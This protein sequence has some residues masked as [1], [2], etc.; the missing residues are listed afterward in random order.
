MA[1]PVTFGKHGTRSA[2]VRL[3]LIAMA[4]L[5]SLSSPV[6]A[7]PS[8]LTSLSIEE[9][10]DLKVTSVSKK[11]QHLSD[12][13]AAIYVITN[14]DLRR[15]GVTHIPDALRMVPG[16]NVARIT[17]NK[18]AVNSRG[19]TSR[20]SDKLL[21]LIDGRSIY[22]PDFSGVLW[23]IQDV[24]IDDIERIEVIRGP[25][26]TLWGANAVNGVIN[27]I[28]KSAA[29][30]QG[31]LVS[32]GA[33][34]Y[35][36]A[37]A[38]LRYGGRIGQSTHYR[39]FAKGFERDSFKYSDDGDA[40]DDW[41]MR[42]AGF[43]FDSELTAGDSLTVQGDFFQSDSHRLM[44]LPSTVPP[45]VMSVDDDSDASGQ[46]MLTRWQRVFS[47]TSDLT[48]QAYYNRNQGEDAWTDT[49]RDT[50]DVDLQH[51]FR[52][53]E[54]HDIIWGIR[55]NRTQDEFDNT[56]VLFLDPSKRTDNLYSTFLQDEITLVRD[57]LWFTVG[58]KLE[59]NDYTGYE[60]QPGARLFWSP[61][62]KHKL[63]T[64]VSRA[65]RTPSRVESD[66][67]MVD[68]VITP[69]DMVT[70]PILLTFKGH[71]DLTAERLVAYEMGYRFLPAA[72]VS[73]DLS[74]FYNDYK[75]LRAFQ[76]GT[77]IFHGTYIEQPL[78]YSYDYS[79]HTYGAELA[80]A[81][82]VSDWLKLDLAYGYLD[83][84]LEDSG[85]LGRAPKHQTS[86]R[87]AFKLRKD[88]DLN[89][90]LRYVDDATA[91]KVD[92]AD[93]FYH[94]NDYFTADLRLAW[95]PVSSVE[96]SIVGQNLLDGSHLEF[97]EEAYTHPTEVQRNIYGKITYRF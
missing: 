15:S 74:L 62:E 19:S 41:G 88:L 35:E 82:Q 42:H 17:S 52:A 57:R 39:V 58:S 59:H 69:T 47:S 38:D 96:L 4:V 13:A 89:V 16:L 10:M 70:P 86:L 80:L 49:E 40:G 71:E 72:A 76:A 5:I 44:A 60:V 45:Y 90:W 29:D 23:E 2:A 61:A 77:P 56:I 33:G 43:R 11:A 64:A 31:G 84:D 95:R 1:E 26:A 73:V 18:W 81:W 54:R 91:V 14:E 55:Y 22:S 93:Y 24:M 12:S 30:T 87:S 9:L 83:C 75:N 85:Q 28:T 8:D 48:F 94:I 66:A 97:V 32:A 67:T 68:N 27:I 25:G 7:E 78:T 6:F 53:A 65:V 51:H 50:I 63:W 79:A 34:D 20:Y 92:E 36:K 46:N 37:F 3:P 21:V